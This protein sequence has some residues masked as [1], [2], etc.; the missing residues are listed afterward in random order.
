MSGQ[1]SVFTQSP[2][3]FLHGGPSVPTGYQSL[4]GTFAGASPQP[5]D[6]G[7]LV[8]NSG[9]VPLSIG[10]I[11]MMSGSVPVTQ[12]QGGQLPPGGQPSLM[13]GGYFN[14]KVLHSC[15]GGNLKVSTLLWGN[16]YLKVNPSLN[17]YPKVNLSI[18][19]NLKDGNLKDGNP[20]GINPKGINLKD[21]N[22]KVKVNPSTRIYLKVI[23]LR[24]NTLVKVINH[25]KGNHMG[26][27]LTIINP[28]LNPAMDLSILNL[29]WV[30][31][32]EC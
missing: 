22:L 7:L 16:T 18:N 17:M 12:P 29:L 11:Y 1:S 26:L 20:K 10:D 21:T 13:P 31:T 14:L 6:H 28:I 3:S 30:N 4:S 9:N 15:L 27:H 23:N 19:I 8:G 2:E 24:V 5:I 25:L 32:L